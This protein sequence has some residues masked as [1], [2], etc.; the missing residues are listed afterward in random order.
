MEDWLEKLCLV[1]L[2]VLALAAMVLVVITC[3][4]AIMWFF[5]VIGAI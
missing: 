2:N 4:L 3:L 5:D 1:A